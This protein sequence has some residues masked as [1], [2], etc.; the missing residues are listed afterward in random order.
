MLL[1]E[2]IDRMNTTSPI[3]GRYPWY[4]FRAHEIP[5][6]S[7]AMSSFVPY[8]HCPTP[9]VI[10]EAFSHFYDKAEHKPS[11]LLNTSD[12]DSRRMFVN[13]QWALGGKGTGAPVHFHFTAW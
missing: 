6:A 8:Y 3:G 13:A 9:Q 5:R 10:Q 1:G 4:V 7:E 11:S 2:Y 12:S